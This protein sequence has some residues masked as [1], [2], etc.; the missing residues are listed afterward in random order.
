MRTELKWTE[1][2]GNGSRFG[3]QDGKHPS[4]PVAVTDA[5]PNTDNHPG[6]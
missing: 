6:S 5:A 4:V 1:M 3:Q 2:H